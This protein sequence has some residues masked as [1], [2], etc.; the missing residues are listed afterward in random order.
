MANEVSDFLLQS[1]P[2]FT[3]VGAVALG[4]LNHRRA[5]KT[6]DQ[7]RFQSTIEELHGLYRSL[8]ED[9]GEQ[10]S[11]LRELNVELTASNLELLGTLAEL[12]KENGALS[13]TIKTLITR[14][15]QLETPKRKP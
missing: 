10:V 12:R 13:K 14:V 3:A 5:N 1:A 11:R 2:W 8:V 9:L 15:S 7:D 4:Y 6:S